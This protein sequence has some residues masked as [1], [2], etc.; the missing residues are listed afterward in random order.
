MVSRRTL[1]RQHMILMPPYAPLSLW[2]MRSPLIERRRAQMG[3]FTCWMNSRLEELLLEQ[4]LPALFALLAET[5]PWRAIILGAIAIP[6]PKALGACAGAIRGLVFC[7]CIC[8]SPPTAARR[9]Q[10]GWPIDGQYQAVLLA[11]PSPGVY[12]GC[13]GGQHPAS[14]SSKGACSCLCSL[15]EMQRQRLTTLGPA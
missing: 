12:Q 11:D 8:A 3:Q 4:P 15:I 13:I 6:G 9:H 5:R 14:K 10:L 7:T 1:R 2:S